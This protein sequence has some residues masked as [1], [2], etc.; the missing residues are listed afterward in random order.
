[1]SLTVGIVTDETDLAKIYRL[2][3]KVYCQEWGFDNNINHSREI[4]TDVYDEHAVH[5]C[6]Q[7]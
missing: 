4:I 6:C 3:Y 1:M 5:F 2:R 7:G